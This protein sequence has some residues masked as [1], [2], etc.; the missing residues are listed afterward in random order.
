MKRTP[1]VLAAAA[2]VAAGTLA[3]PAASAST[4]TPGTPGLTLLGINTGN[5]TPDGYIAFAFTLTNNSNRSG[6][7]SLAIMRPL[8]NTQSHI[9]TCDRGGRDGLFCEP[10]DFVPGESMT[11]LIQVQVKDQPVAPLV[12]KVRACAMN[13]DTG[14]TGPCLLQKVPIAS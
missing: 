5:P 4:G 7:I 13:E 14:V 6:V 2:L 9:F 1:V 8:Y 12:V 10:G 11:S 3:I